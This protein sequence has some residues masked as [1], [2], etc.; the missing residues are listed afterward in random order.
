ML[1]ELVQYMAKQIA[2]SLHVT[3]VLYRTAQN[4][5]IMLICKLFMIFSKY[6]HLSY[7][8]SRLVFQFMIKA[9]PYEFFSIRLLTQQGHYDPLEQYFLDISVCLLSIYIIYIYIY[10]VGVDYSDIIAN[11]FV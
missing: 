4:A 10:G 8:F 9:H 5:Y 7:I 6:S 3:Y 1:H 2:H 11:Y